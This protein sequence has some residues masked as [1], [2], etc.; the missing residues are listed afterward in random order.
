MTLVALPAQACAAGTLVLGMYRLGTCVHAR[1]CPAHPAHSGSR[2]HQQ[3]QGRESGP[4]GRYPTHSTRPACCA[5]EAA[6]LDRAAAPAAVHAPWH[7]TRAPHATAADPPPSQHCSGPLP[8]DPRGQQG[9]WGSHPEHH[10][11]ARAD[12]RRQLRDGLRQLHVA[13]VQLGVDLHGHVGAV[14]GWRGGTSGCRCRRGLQS[15]PTPGDGVCCDGVWGQRSR[16]LERAVRQRSL[17]SPVHCPSAH[18]AGARAPGS[19]CRPVGEAGQLADQGRAAC[20]VR[21]PTR[22]HGAQSWAACSPGRRPATPPPHQGQPPTPSWPPRTAT[23]RPACCR[24]P[25]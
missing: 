25:A 12:G 11:G 14:C 10:E 9:G 5:G 13:A 4:P 3:Q 24:W 7:H 6:R 18:T 17:P 15:W 20:C 16:A 8:I 1:S 2:A 23:A 19:R 22:C 21:R